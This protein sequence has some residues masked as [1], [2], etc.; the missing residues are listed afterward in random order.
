MINVLI[1]EDDAMVSHI[2]AIYLNQIE[3]FHLEGQVASVAEARDVIKQQ[4]IDLILLDIYMPQQT[5]LELLSYIR[6]YEKGIDVIIISAASDTDS[7]QYALQ[8]GVSDYIIKPFQFE[9]FQHALL[10]YQE[11]QRIVKEKKQLNQS[12]LDQLLGGDLPEKEDD[13]PM[14]PKGITQQTLTQIS[15]CVQAFGDKGFSTEQLANEVGMSRI[16][17]RKYLSFLEQQQVI[18]SYIAYGNVGRPL[19]MYK[20]LPHRQAM[21]ATYL[22]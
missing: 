5:G 1:V 10:S 19:T 3:G 2:N 18:T 21:I 8:N 17:I 12:E 4:P 6:K 22:E 7:I 16:S 20:C 14:L 15:E 13:Q 11:K 9:R